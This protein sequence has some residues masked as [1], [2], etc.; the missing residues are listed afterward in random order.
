MTWKKIKK[1]K[2]NLYNNEAMNFYFKLITWLYVSA[3]VA[4]AGLTVYFQVKGM[5]EE[6]IYTL[7]CVFVCGIMLGVRT[8][9]KKR[10]IKFEQFM[11][12]KHAAEQAKKKSEK[13]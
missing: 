10:L 12:E 4:A 8:W 7:G 6:A 2:N 1:R 11:Q 9:Q 13:K 3:G 5:R